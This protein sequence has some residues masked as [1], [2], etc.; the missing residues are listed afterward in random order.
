MFQLDTYW[1]NTTKIIITGYRGILSWHRPLFPSIVAKSWTIFT[2]K[3]KNNQIFVF[4]W[5]YLTS[6]VNSASLLNWFNK[7]PFLIRLH[8]FF[9]LLP[10]YLTIPKK[11]LSATNLWN[12]HSSNAQWLG[13][14]RYIWSRSLKYIILSQSQSIFS[15]PCNL[16]RY[17]CVT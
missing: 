1:T 10:T 8:K 9:F 14:V 6:T 4:R 11:N 12:F 16:F 2:W 17:F 3:T 7:S 15:W 5:N 13:D